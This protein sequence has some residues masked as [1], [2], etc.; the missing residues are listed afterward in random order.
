[1]LEELQNRPAELDDIWLDIAR[2]PAAPNAQTVWWRP[3]R[4]VFT[5]SPP[6]RALAG[7]AATCAQVY[8]ASR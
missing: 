6:I 3:S 4:A 1:M 8:E 7:S 2:E 5:C